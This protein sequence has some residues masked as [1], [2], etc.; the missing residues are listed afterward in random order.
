MALSP[1]QVAQ[2]AYQAGFRG[3]ALIQIVAIAKRE[4]GYRPEAWR[5]DNPGGST[6]D[7]GLLQINYVNW[8]NVSRALGLSGDIR[9]LL[10]PLTNLRAAKYLYDQSG[11][12]P[13]AA[14]AGGWTA[15]GDPLYGTNVDAAAAAV[16]NAGS[17]GL[18][19][20]D[21]AG[22]GGVGS[23]ISP[24]AT[25]GVGEP[26]QRT[27]E[28]PSDAQIYVIDGTFEVYAVFDLGGVKVAYTIDTAAGATNWVDKPRTVV[29]RNDWDALGTVN[30]GSSNELQTVQTTFGTYRAFWDS[31]LG[32]VMGYNNPARTD[33]EV[34]KV[35]AE[36]AARPDMSMTELQNKLQATSWF[37]THT[38]SQLEWNGL[39]EAEKRKRLDDTAS[40][41]IATW[42]QYGGVFIDSSDPRIANYVE[43]VASGELGFGAWTE[44]VK[45]AAA[46]MPESPWAREQRAEGEAQRQRPIDIENTAQRIRSQLNR[47]GLQ[48]R[49]DEVQRWARE[50]V[51]KRSSDDDL[52]EAM[53]TQAQVLYPWKDREMET[54]TAAEPWLAV[55]ER[56][57]ESPASLQSPEI[58]AALTGGTPAW[59]FEQQ[60]KK[61]S[62]WLGTKNGQ[63]SITDAIAEAGRR[64][65][66]V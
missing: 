5:T 19:G 20:Q 13:W 3:Q 8:P 52:I 48:W 59:E 7:F 28:L 6:G 14:A 61:S 39:S 16:R 57:L 27:T 15:G 25:P 41:M 36:F 4:S 54:V 24:T 21:W 37:Q 29:S 58:Q 34:Q 62:K 38:S 23:A 49:E 55:H 42:Q 56:V 2:V 45:Q 64:M 33:P 12:A 35:I 31:I 63:A 60:L 10:D 11:L 47:W 26:A 40:R 9:Q 22:G 17:Q 53:K 46:S 44:T 43:R 30:A 50:I 66:F 65:G 51:E 1:E 18:L 32:Q